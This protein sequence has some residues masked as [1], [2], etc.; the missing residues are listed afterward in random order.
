ML[1]TLGNS[2]R[3]LDRLDEAEAALRRGLQII[4]AAQPVPSGT[5]DGVGL[6]GQVSGSQ[7]AGDLGASAGAPRSVPVSGAD[8]GGALMDLGNLQRA[9]GKPAEAIATFRRALAL[10]E[11]VLGPEHTRTGDVHGALAAALSEAGQLDEAEQEALR[12]LAI[13]RARQGPDGLVTAQSHE[14]LARIYRRKGELGRSLA[15]FEEALRILEA[16]PAAPHARLVNALWTVGDAHMFLDQ[17]AQ[18]RPLYDRALAMLGDSPEDSILRAGIELSLA[19][20]LGASLDDRRRAIE[21][22]RDAR[23]R[24]LEQQHDTHN[25]D[26]VLE[27]AE[28]ALPRRPPR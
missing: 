28:A 17:P 23:R 11:P 16:A 12:A 19:Q 9:Q 26:T 21:L 25:V 7:P 6:A 14:R 1:Q 15:S 8:I 18:A 20:T 2:L 22:L 13:D 27:Q 24:Y 4:E 5:P 3:A 10:I